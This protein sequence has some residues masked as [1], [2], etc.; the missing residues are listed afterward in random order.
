MQRNIHPSDLLEEAI[1]V[2]LLRYLEYNKDTNPAYFKARREVAISR[3]ALQKLT[4]AY[5]STV[6]WL[7]AAQQQLPTDQAQVLT[8]TALVESK[9][10]SLIEHALKVTQTLKIGADIEAVL[11]TRLDGVQ[12]YSV[13]SQLP[14]LLQETVTRIT[15]DPQLAAS[16]AEDFNRALQGALNVI[17]S[18]PATAGHITEKQVIDMLNSVPLTNLAIQ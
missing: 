10:R 8:L 1:S 14:A 15:N 13:I 12:V 11:S 18:T 3:L 7:E 9:G 2:N 4:D 16:I 5:H 6:V 17:D